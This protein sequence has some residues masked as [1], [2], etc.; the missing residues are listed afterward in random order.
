MA[1]KLGRLVLAVTERSPVRKVFTGTKPGRAL[2]TRFVAGETLDDAVAVARDLNEVGATVSLDH[3]GAHVT[4]RAQAIEARDDYLAAL[5]RLAFEDLDGNVSVKLTQLGLGTDDDMAAASLASLAERAASLGRSVTVDMEESI[6]TEATITLYEKTQARYGNLGV[7]LQSYLHRS[8][9]D[10]ERVIAAG[11][12]VRICKG[13]YAESDEIALQAGSEVDASFDEMTRTAMD[14]EGII[15][16]IAT[17]DEHRM[18]IAMEMAGTREAPWEFQMLYG[19]R[20]KLQGELLASGYPLR[21]YV[22]YG[23][24]W[25]PYLTRRL[26]ERPANVWFFLRA[27][28]G[29]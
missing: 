26:A 29:R 14:A 20:R 22:P 9:A 3:L 7:A 10:L 2:S 17:H 24:A 21:V 4:D 16:A 15:P 19:V 28:T 6:Y 18:A 13:A 8:A 27:A 1:S 23:V 12:H 5:D 25:Y 11:G